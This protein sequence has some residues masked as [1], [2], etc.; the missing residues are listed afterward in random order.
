MCILCL[1]FDSGASDDCDALRMSFDNDLLLLEEMAKFQGDLNQ[2]FTEQV[3]KDFAAQTTGILDELQRAQAVKI[4]FARK[5][6]G[7]S[8]DAKKAALKRVKAAYCTKC[9]RLE[10]GKFSNCERCPENPDCQPKQ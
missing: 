8:V 9:S 10:G 5:R 2:K 3:Q 7:R 4:A 1:S 6:L